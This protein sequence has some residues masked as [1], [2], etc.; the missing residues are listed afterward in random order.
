MA[1]TGGLRAEEREG[2]VLE[3]AGRVALG[4]EVGDLLELEGALQ[5]GGVV[6]ALA[7]DEGVLRGGHA[8]AEAL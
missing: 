4:V 3:L 8:G 5:G 1:M 2:A 7:D 6:G